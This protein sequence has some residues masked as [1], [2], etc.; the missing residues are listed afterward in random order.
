LRILIVSATATE[1]RFDILSNIKVGIPIK[2]S[3]LLN[4]DIDILVTGIGAV[5]AAFALARYAEN[6]DLVIN[7]GIAGSFKPDFPIGTVVCVKVDCFGDYGVDDKGA[8]KSL[9]EMSFSSNDKSSLEDLLYNPWLNSEF[10]ELKMPLVKGVT[11]ATASGSEEV[12]G[13]VNKRWNADIETMESASVFYVC[14]MLGVKFICFRA[15]SNIVEPRDRSKWEIGKAISNLDEEVR[16][17][18]KS[19]P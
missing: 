8:F 6:Y 12:I 19:L 13:K 10:I 2:V 11:L 1:N 15:I 7:I 5:P 18:I 4:H 16:N 17:F 9:S 3:K 14:G